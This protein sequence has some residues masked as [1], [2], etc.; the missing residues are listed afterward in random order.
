M[1]EKRQH[2]RIPKNVKSEVHSDEGMTFSTSTNLSNGGIFISTPEPVQIGSEVQLSI[3]VP[4]EEEIDIKGIVRW[5]NESETTEC[6]T[7]MGIEFVGISES[8]KTKLKK[9]MEYKSN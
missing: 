6:R 1:E 7:G 4:D 8:Q 2:Q 9:V 5:M 3:T